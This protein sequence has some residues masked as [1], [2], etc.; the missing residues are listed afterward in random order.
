MVCWLAF[1]CSL[2]TSLLSLWFSVGL[3]DFQ[4]MI[5]IKTKK[6]KEAVEQIRSK[7]PVDLEPL[8]A[9][10]DEVQKDISRKDKTTRKLVK[11]SVI[12]YGIAL[13]VFIVIGIRQLITA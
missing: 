8:H 1:V 12:C 10:M 13:S 7:S 9:I 2:V 5:M 4:A 11:A 3:Q 6:I